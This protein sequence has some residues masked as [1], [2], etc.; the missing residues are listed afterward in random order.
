MVTSI[1]TLIITR[2]T[3]PQESRSQRRWGVWLLPCQEPGGFHEGGRG[4]AGHGHHEASLRKVEEA[5]RR[6]EEGLSGGVRDK[7]G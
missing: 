3:K 1:I 6:R 4:P 2:V 5:Q 7:E